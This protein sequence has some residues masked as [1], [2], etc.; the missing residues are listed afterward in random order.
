MVKFILF[1]I[2]LRIVMVIQMVATKVFQK[3]DE[4]DLIGAWLKLIIQYHHWK[5]PEH[6]G[7]EEYTQVQKRTRESSGYYIPTC[8]Q[9]V[10]W[11]FI[12]IIFL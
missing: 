8:S 3:H 4:S 6:S 1:M 11:L 10:I 5:K 9:F 12:V 7:K 2:L